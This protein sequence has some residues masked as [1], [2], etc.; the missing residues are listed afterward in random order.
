MPLLT[1]ESEADTPFI[2]LKASFC[3]EP[4]VFIA[5]SQGCVAHLSIPDAILIRFAIAVA[6]V[7]PSVAL[8][9]ATWAV[10]PV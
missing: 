6:A 8:T 5:R 1:D 4:A 9:R 7:V 2:R 10:V 3:D